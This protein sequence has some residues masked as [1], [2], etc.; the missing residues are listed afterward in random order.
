MNLNEQETWRVQDSSKL[1]DFQVCPRKYFYAHVLGWKPTSP[2]ID[3]I[4]G[5]AWHQ[6]MEQLLKTGYSND[7]VQLAYLLLLRRYREDFDVVM[8]DSYFPKCPGFAMTMLDRYIR[9]YKHDLD[10][11]N[12]L[13]TE[14][15]GSVSLSEKYNIHFKMDDVLQ[16]KSGPRSG[17][18]FS[19]EHKTTKTI[20]PVWIETHTLKIQPFVYTHVLRCLYG[21][22]TDGII[23]N[24]GQFQKTNPDFFRFGVPKTLPQMQCWHFEI[25]QLLDELDRNFQT[26]THCTED[27]PILFCFPRNGESCTKYMRVCSYFDFCTAWS[28]PLQYIGSIPMGFKE[29][30][31]DPRSKP[32]THNLGDIK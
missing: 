17:K 12:V 26:L 8:D 24:V 13:Y 29:D 11:F 4:F 27:D 14:I 6:A 28:N 1:S 21:D 10:T 31:W 18:Y 30:H 9:K 22:E 19:L 2:N 32:T 15:S 7:S 5:D 3:L 25:I 16:W 23:Y 20:K